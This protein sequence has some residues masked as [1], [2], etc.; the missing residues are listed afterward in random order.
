MTFTIAAFLIFVAYMSSGFAYMAAWKFTPEK[1]MEQLQEENDDLRRDLLLT[2][3]GELRV[4]SLIS[5]S[6]YTAAWPLY[7]V[8]DFIHWIRDSHEEKSD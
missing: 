2:T 3:E 6:Y 8:E 4:I 5:F 7:L 1:L